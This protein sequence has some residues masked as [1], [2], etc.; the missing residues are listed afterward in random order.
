MRRYFWRSSLITAGVL[1]ILGGALALL[2]ASAVPSA[3]YA[4]SYWLGITAQSG[5]AL[6]ASAAIAS[7]GGAIEGARVRSA[8]LNKTSAKRGFL[9]IATRSLAPT[10]IA[11]LLIQAVSFL[12]YVK[13]AAGATDAP[14][15]AVLFAF[16]TIIAAHMLFGFNL[17]LRVPPAI[18]YPVALTASYAWL[19][20]AWSVNYFALRYMAGLVLIDCCRIDLELDHRAINTAIVFNLGIATALL[21]FARGRLKLSKRLPSK[22]FGAA[23]AIIVATILFATQLASPLGPF[24]LTPRDSANM[25]CKDSTGNHRYLREARQSKT[26]SKP[27]ICFFGSQDQRGLFDESLRTT[28][29]KLR[30]LD[31][32]VP[33]VIVASTQIESSNEIG[34][35]AR[36]IASPTIVAR[37]LV[38]DFV[39]QPADCGT[40]D[41]EWSARDLN[42]RY[43]MNFLLTA[44]STKSLDLVTSAPPLEPEESAKFS[45]LRHW[46]EGFAKTGTIERAALPWLKKSFGAITDCAA[47]VPALL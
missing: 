46:A 39:S 36:P 38:S 1:F 41:E 12:A 37:S 2:F 13:F 34:V 35:V 26:Q 24:A 5:I 44:T 6:I 15:F 3:E 10:F 16:A 30:K 31:L 33:P 22:T 40:T 28:W 25:L 43:L 14:N 7:L 19:G 4:T 29:Q 45:T 17:G 21:L 32:H 9:A 8:K 27:E 42:Y 47:E 20:A 11:A 18:A 23:I